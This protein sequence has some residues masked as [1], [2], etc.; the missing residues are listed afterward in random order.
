VVETG[1]RPF[2]VEVAVSSVDDEVLVPPTVCVVCELG[3]GTEVGLAVDPASPPSQ[4]VAN[5]AR[6][7]HAIASRPAK[8]S[9]SRP[10]VAM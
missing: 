10:A 2:V 1:I 6:H 7:A 5:N 8:P 3:A 4:P 9:V